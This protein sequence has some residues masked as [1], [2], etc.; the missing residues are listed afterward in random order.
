MNKKT[1]IIII[2][3]LIVAG[4]VGYLVWQKNQEDKAIIQIEGVGKMK[5]TED[6]FDAKGPNG[7]SIQINEGGVKITPPKN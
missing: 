7:G 1:V 3:V 6:S 4:V 5:I 2:G